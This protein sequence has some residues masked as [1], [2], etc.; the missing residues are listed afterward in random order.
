[1]AIDDDNDGAV[2][3]DGA[4]LQQESRRRSTILDDQRR[5]SRGWRWLVGSALVC[6]CHLPVTLAL[7]GTALGGTAMGAL[8]HRHIVPAGLVIGAVW[9]F[10]TWRGLRLLSQ[11][12]S[13]PVPR[14]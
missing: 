14:R 4:A 5:K 6:P 3:A 1:M 13:C 11:R 8:L 10:V 9:L 7:L 2:R 12:S